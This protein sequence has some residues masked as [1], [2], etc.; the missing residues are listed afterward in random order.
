[1]ECH[2]IGREEADSRRENV[3]AV[4]VTAAKDPI[5]TRML[6]RERIKVAIIAGVQTKV[7]TRRTMES[8][9]MVKN[10]KEDKMRG[11]KNEKG[12]ELY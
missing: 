7:V 3:D 5:G 9:R 1:M 8:A 6:I 4:R 11:T 2:P 12:C 10:E